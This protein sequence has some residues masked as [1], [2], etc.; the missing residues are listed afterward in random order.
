V[1]CADD[2][3]LELLSRAIS[4]TVYIFP[5]NMEFTRKFPVETL[6]NF[7]NTWGIVVESLGILD[8]SKDVERVNFEVKSRFV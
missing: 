5:L 6:H 3:S 8:I 4:S 1:A 2:K 7:F